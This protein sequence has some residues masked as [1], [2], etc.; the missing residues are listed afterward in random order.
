MT[1]TTVPAGPLQQ[2]ALQLEDAFRRK[3]EKTIAEMELHIQ[4]LLTQ[5]PNNPMT[6]FLLGNFYSKRE[7]YGMAINIYKR[8]LSMAPDMIQAYNNL[9]TIHKKMFNMDEA[10]RILL[11]G[12]QL[13]GETP[14][15]INNLCT[16]YVN[17]GR[18]K[19]GIEWGEKAINLGGGKFPHPF[20]NYAL[21]LLE[22]GELHRGFSYYDYGFY[23]GDRIERHYNVERNLPYW[24]GTKGQRLVVF[25]EQG[26]GDRILFANL[27]HKVVEDSESVIFEHHPRLDNVYHRSFPNIDYFYPTAKEGEI[28]WPGRHLGEI[29]ARVAIGSLPRFYWRKEREID[30]TPYMFPKQ[31]LVKKMRERLG[32]T[33]PGPYVGIGWK[34]GVEHTNSQARSCKLGHLKSILSLP[35]TFVSIQYRYTDEDDQLRRLG[36]ETGGTLH[37]WP[38]VVDAFDYDM[39]L[40][41]FHALDITVGPCTAAFHMCGASGAPYWCFVPRQKAWRYRG[42]TDGAPE[43]ESIYYGSH[44]RMF[45]QQPDEK[46]WF[47][48][49]E[50]I[51]L[52][53]QER[54]K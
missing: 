49:M 52:K 43:S 32:R 33:G 38:E 18:P 23:T 48:V 11:T 50:R 12:L 37:H 3:D 34:G 2:L 22:L 20:W 47:P 41:L 39:S 8:C 46:D 17:E 13:G 24:D 27:L 35:C 53:L 1:T 36:L 4:K 45:Q 29:D 26:L 19:E 30:R 10:E 21:L 5:D 51:A 54:L 25:D 7:Q 40:A 44:V 9:G 42:V 15:I 31:S 28:D 14:E 6:L 16:I